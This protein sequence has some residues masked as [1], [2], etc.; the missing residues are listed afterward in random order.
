MKRFCLILC[1]LLAALSASPALAEVYTDEW[2]NGV[3]LNFEI[4]ASLLQPLDIF[5][6]IFRFDRDDSSDEELSE[7]KAL[8]QKAMEITFKDAIPEIMEVPKDSA[9]LLL[10]AYDNEWGDGK[11]AWLHESSLSCFNFDIR[12]NY[13]G[14][15][16]FI[17][18][19]YSRFSTFQFDLADF[20]ATREDFFVEHDFM[21]H[22]EADAQAQAFMT[23]LRGEDSPFKAVLRD[24]Y[25]ITHEQV[26]DVVHWIREH[27]DIYDYKY[28]ADIDEE[29]DTYEWTDV[30]D[31][32]YLLYS[33]TYKG[34]PI[35]DWF[36][37]YYAGNSLTGI[38]HSGYST[39]FLISREG[40]IEAHESML[41]DCDASPYEDTP[42]LT[43]YEALDV[44]KE[45][46]GVIPGLNPIEITRV[47][48]EYL[49]YRL[50]GSS[51]TIFEPIWSF[52]ADTT[53]DYGVLEDYMVYR[54][55]GHTGAIMT[56]GTGVIEE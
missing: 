11:C 14:A 44:L 2:D 20:P 35:C 1:L 23:A 38:S 42:A 32:Y 9:S 28:K 10:K 27:D 39:E 34:Y 17:D 40:F 30:Y 46:L 49:P 56:N 43:L 4:D 52:V 8:L 29:L 36:Q 26:A 16:E 5:D 3:T 50:E 15:H 53:T 48:V 54:V 7:R 25:G 47:Y 41:L 24:W 12:K 33:Y 31:C 18:T 55:N 6:V 45:Y 51:I 37:T 21:T 19:D 13:K 22:E